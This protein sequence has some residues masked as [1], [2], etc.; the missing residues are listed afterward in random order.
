MMRVAVVGS[1]RR[2]GA[3]LQIFAESPDVEIVAVVDADLEAPVLRL[4]RE[5]GIST[6]NEHQAVFRY[7]PEVVIVAARNPEILED[8]LSE[9]PAGM[10]LMG[11]KSARLLWD[12]VEA[13]EQSARRLKT[14]LLLSQSITSTL[15]LETVL[16]LI[17]EAA[18]NLL[19]AD[20]AGLWVLQEDSGEPALRASAG[21]AE[22]LARSSATLVW[23]EGLVR[24]VAQGKG[25]YPRAEIVA[26]VG[27]FVGVPLV[28]DGRIL[29][30]LGVIGRM[31]HPFTEAD[32]DLLDSFASQVALALENARLYGEIR[33]AL[34][35]LTA[36][37]QQ[38]VQTARLRAL[39]EMAGGVAHDFN[40]VLAVIL[41]R[42]R[43]LLDQTEEPEL[44]RQLKVIEK[45]AL[46]GGQTVRRIQEFTRMRQ[47]R[48]FQ[49]VDLNRV[50]EEVVEITR[51]RWKD[52]AQGKGI[53]Y[54]IRVETRPIP[55]VAGD[56]SDLREALA[57]LVFNA[58]DAMPEGGRVT[59][60]TELQ[61]EHVICAVSDTG[62][63]ITEE[64][65][66]RVFAPFF[67]T[68]GER[69]T[70]LGLSIV[71]GIITRHG[72]EIEVQ[73]QVGRGSLFTIR[74][75]L[76]RDISEGPSSAP[77]ARPPRM[78]KILVIDDEPEFREVLGELLAHQGHAVAT[79]AD[80][81]A[82]LARLQEEAFDLVITDLGMPGLSGWEVVRLVKHRYPATPVALITGWRDRIDPDEARA[83]GVDFLVAKPFKFEDII[84]VV[85][86]ALT[87]EDPKT[88]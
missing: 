14:L 84:E 36:S 16:D 11:A 19:E 23:V 5:R 24:E 75:P 49:P 70:G 52:E 17:V 38:I 71:Y 50:V 76:G 13:R 32:Q 8:L 9:R 57:N 74:L 30:V 39:G 63:G 62:T 85:A 88:R 43:L 41:G 7:A 83:K 56:P 78:G 10:E 21:A 53:G 44:Q 86:C 29:G 79:S 4:A 46:D 12:S 27:T 35:E 51:S 18:V 69:G 60:Q 1:G 42:A 66:K 80:G 3:L 2:G 73:S 25:G 37:R 34:E 67:T 58:L 40:N 47:A 81:R 54:D 28:K 48:A 45:A 82:G 6:V 72:G 64:V 31:A 68:K 55:P 22:L 59:F 87:P 20:V 26:P 65:R 33:A 15:H 77:L 61:G